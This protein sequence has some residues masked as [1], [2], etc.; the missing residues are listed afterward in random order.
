[1]IPWLTLGP[2]QKVIPELQVEDRVVQRTLNKGLARLWSMQTR[3][4]G[5][6]YWPGNNE[7]MLWGSA[8]AA[9][10][11]GLARDQ[12]IQEES[13]GYNRLKEYLS[14]SI[15]N[16]AET[17]N[18]A[19]LEAQVMAVAALSTMGAA[20]PAY[21]EVLFKRRKE[22]SLESRRFL[23]LA[24]AGSSGPEAMVRNLLA[25]SNPPQGTTSWF[26]STERLR[27]L[28]LMTLAT[29]GAPIEELDKAFDAMLQGSSNGHWRTTQGNAWSILAAISYHEANPSASDPVKAVLT[30]QGKSENVTPDAETLTIVRDFTGGNITPEML[31]A[32]VPEGGR[33]YSEVRLE[34]EL[35]KAAGAMAE[36]HGFSLVRSYTRLAGD[37]SVAED[38]RLVAGDKVLVTL[39]LNASADSEY[40]AI[41]D[42]LPALFEPIN[43]DLATQAAG[44]AALAG[45]DN[46]YL[47]SYRELREDRAIFFA[48][49]LPAG[50]HV[51]RYLARVRH[52]GTATAPG[53]QAECMYDPDVRGRTTELVVNAT[54][55]SRP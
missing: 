30:W 53:T 4:G 37:G 31:T 17:K 27:A 26:G 12:G 46:S 14:T 25:D 33:I 54:P 10:A 22:L 48:D 7:S 51:I 39:V 13:T 6:S 38:Q 18:A 21:H 3:D 16:A 36:N 55:Q 23:A 35:D 15:R 28:E 32:S 47:Q 49:E 9:I 11:I 24:I 29:L 40:V 8:Y 44:G 2:L 19:E 45:F 43:P 20:E 1:L 34:A 52:T 41:E 42:P 5:L 50:Q